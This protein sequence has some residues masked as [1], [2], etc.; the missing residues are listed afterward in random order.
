MPIEAIRQCYNV[1][2][3]TLLFVLLIKNKRGFNPA[4]IIPLLSLL[5]RELDQVK[6]PEILYG[7]GYKHPHGR[8]DDTA[9]GHNGPE[10]FAAAFVCLHDN[11][12]LAL[13][14]GNA[15]GVASI[16]VGAVVCCVLV[17]AQMSQVVTP[18]FSVLTAISGLHRVRQV[19]IPPVP[20][21]FCEKLIQK[22]L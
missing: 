16:T 11:L 14:P 9:V 2:F 7:G 21:E 12:I 8:L 17:T 13:L 20:I 4:Y 6:S 19:T 5:I 15:G 3:V 10:N 22:F 18:G 1:Q